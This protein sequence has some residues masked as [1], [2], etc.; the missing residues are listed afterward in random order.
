MT[1][2]EELIHNSITENK[3]QKNVL[4]QLSPDNGK[5][6]PFAKRHFMWSVPFNKVA[7]SPRT[8]WTAPGLA[9]VVRV[10]A[11]RGCPAGFL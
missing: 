8:L 3:T 7:F 1:D 10:H 6:G 2:L 4:P 9:T 5:V 11:P